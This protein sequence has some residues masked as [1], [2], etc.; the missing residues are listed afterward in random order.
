MN[1][2]LSILV[3]TV[4]SRIDTFYLLIMKNILNQVKPYGKQIEVLGLLDN[5]IRTTG[6]KREEMLKMAKGKYLV[7]IDD[8]DRIADDYVLYI[9]NTLLNNPFA[10]CVVF[11][12]ICRVNGGIDKLCKYGVEFEYGDINE[13]REWRGKPAHTMVYRSEIAKRH[14]FKH[15]TNGEDYDWVLRASR[16]IINQVRIDKVLYYYDAQYATTSETV[17]LPDEVIERNI[18]LLR[19]NTPGMVHSPNN[20]LKQYAYTLINNVGSRNGDN[21]LSILRSLRR[22]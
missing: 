11:D 7:F 22:R 6:E 3:P 18:E 16:D 12:C 17:G 1:V 15:L 14:S 4:P 10:D 13:G 8:D 2:L 9:M 21:K 5:K 19:N 20:M